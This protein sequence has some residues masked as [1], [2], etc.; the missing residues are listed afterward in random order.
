[1]MSAPQ[2]SP[3]SDGGPAPVDP[4]LWTLYRAAL[5]DRNF[6]V[7]INWDRTKH[8]AVFNVG[9][10]GIAGG[11]A[12]LGRAGSTLGY[13]A[14]VVLF[15]FVALHS[16]FAV[17]SIKRGHEYYRE[18][19]EQF[20]A[21]QRQLGLIVNNSPGPLA[22]VSTRGMR[23]TAEGK[24]KRSGLT[25]WLTIVNLSMVFQFGIGVAAVVMVIRL[26]VGG[27]AGATLVD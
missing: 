7:N 9:L 16:F 5:D 13:W 21:I 24:A 25:D 8:Y 2:S 20:I 18:S 23:R 1:M 10:F 6:Q 12:Q 19:R 15:G 3:T 4:N 11:I 17:Y 26:V 22:L 14:V 27:I